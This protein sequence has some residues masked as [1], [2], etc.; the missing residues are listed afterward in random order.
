MQ[1]KLLSDKITAM[2][3]LMW[4]YIG[5]LTVVIFLINYAPTIFKLVAKI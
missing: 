3:K 4:L 2:E 1:H 5:G